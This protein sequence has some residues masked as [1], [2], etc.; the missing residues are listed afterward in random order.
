MMDP[1]LAS[2]ASSPCSISPFPKFPQA[3][4]NSH[5]TLPM[6]LS[7]L[8]LGAPSQASFLQFKACASLSTLKGLSILPGTLC[9]SEPPAL[10]VPSCYVIL[11][12][13]ALDCDHLFLYLSAA[14]LRILRLPRTHFVPSWVP[15]T[16]RMGGLPPG[17]SILLCLLSGDWISDIT[18]LPC[19][20]T[21]CSAEECAAADRRGREKGGAIL[22]PSP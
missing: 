18:E 10:E 11:T 2:P 17:L 5:T 7:S 16:W 15:R 1:L 21:F 6:F 22:A 13:T 3:L 9:P 19:L 14:R 20:L 12:L 4:L 8:S